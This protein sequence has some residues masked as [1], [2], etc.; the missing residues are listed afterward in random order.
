MDNTTTAIVIVTKEL[1]LLFLSTK[2]NFIDVKKHNII[3]YTTSLK[4]LDLLR[5]YY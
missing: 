4:H 5:L 1:T 3:N 2:L